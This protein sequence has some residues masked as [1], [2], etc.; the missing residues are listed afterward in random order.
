MSGTGRSARSTNSLRLG[1]WRSFGRLSHRSTPA[2]AGKWNRPSIHAG[3][4]ASRGGT[5]VIRKV[6]A[7]ELPT[8]IALCTGPATVE[9]IEDLYRAL[10]PDLML[11][12]PIDAEAVGEAASKVCDR[13]ARP[14]GPDNRSAGVE[15]TP[16]YPENA[17]PV[18][19]R[20]GSNPLAARGYALW[21]VCSDTCRGSNMGEIMRRERHKKGE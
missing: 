16:G 21:V 9:D 5:A 10:R 18:R 1:D 13:W 8:R 17:R 12:R 15:P 20:A 4:A 6:R 2:G 14:A 3:E 11:V 19:L 7:A